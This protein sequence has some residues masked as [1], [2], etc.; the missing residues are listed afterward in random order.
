[1]D[2]LHEKGFITDPRSN[3][4]SVVFTEEGMD[5]AQRCLEQLFVS[6]SGQRMD[7][8]SRPLSLGFIGPGSVVQ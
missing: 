4:K 6:E 3:A 2:R 1:M 8:D 7:H 5:E